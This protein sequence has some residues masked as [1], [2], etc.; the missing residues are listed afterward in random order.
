[1]VQEHSTGTW[2]A[3]DIFIKASAKYNTTPCWNFGCSKLGSSTHSA[4]FTDSDVFVWL[5]L[6]NANVQIKIH[7][8]AVLFLWK[9]MVHIIYPKPPREMWLPGFDTN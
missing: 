1:M 6:I 5:I 3:S 4:R 2:N 7:T 8:G 9:W